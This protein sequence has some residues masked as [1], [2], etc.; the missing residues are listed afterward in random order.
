MAPASRPPGTLP[1]RVM[2][3]MYPFFE[4]EEAK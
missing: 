2:F 3:D 4:P 1:V